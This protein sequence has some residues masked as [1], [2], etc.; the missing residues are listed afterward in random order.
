MSNK[1]TNP[2]IIAEWPRN[3]NSLLRVE[4]SEFNSHKTV[5][6]REWFTDEFNVPRPSK[7]GLT[8]GIA[9]LER[10]ADA[11]SSAVKVA[12]REGILPAPEKQ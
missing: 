8:V 9:H 10:L 4:L 1:S 2:L 11:L 7:T 12:R 3:R 6:I 5:N